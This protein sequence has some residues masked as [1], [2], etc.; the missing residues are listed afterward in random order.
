MTKL[1]QNFAPLST[2]PRRIGCRGLHNLL[3]NYHHSPHLSTLHSF[4]GSI[5][6]IMVLQPSQAEPTS[7]YKRRNV[8]DGPIRLK[9]SL[10]ATGGR[11]TLKQFVNGAKAVAVEQAPV[12][13]S[14]KQVSNNGKR[15]VVDD[16]PV[17]GPSTRTRDNSQ[18]CV[19]SGD[20][21]L[22]KENS[23][24]AQGDDDG[25]WEEIDGDCTDGTGVNTEEG[26]EAKECF[27]LSVCT[28]L[29][30]CTTRPH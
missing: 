19:Q 1:H 17:P 16:T 30:A 5:E 15:I 26:K 27:I 20:R 23:G 25:S 28:V 3:D 7:P 22:G 24:C 2:S 29:C 21:Q 6:Q 9:P 13:G 8:Q 12:A 14:S 18:T 10:V 4:N 11:V